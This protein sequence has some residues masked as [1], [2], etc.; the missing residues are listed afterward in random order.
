MKKKAWEQ[1]DL[2]PCGYCLLSE[3]KYA[4]GIVFIFWKMQLSQMSA[5]SK[6]TFLR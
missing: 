2:A 6:K 1:P 5:L 4:F 3:V